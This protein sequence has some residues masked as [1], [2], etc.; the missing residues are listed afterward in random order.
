ML[1]TRGAA[2]FSRQRRPEPPKATP[3][4]EDED[5]PPARNSGDGEQ[6]FVFG[7][8]E[9]AESIPLRIDNARATGRLPISLTG[10]DVV[11]WGQASYVDGSGKTIHTKPGR[12]LLVAGK[13]KE[14]G[15]ISGGLALCGGVIDPDGD[16]ELKMQT[17]DLVC[18]VPGT[19]HDLN[20]DI[21]KNNAP[22]VVRAVDGDFVAT[23]RVAGSFQPGAGRTG[24]KSVPYNG[25]GLLAWLDQGNYIRL[26]RGA[27]YRNGRVVGLVIFESRERGARADVHNKGGLDP[28]R[29]IW[30]R[31]ERHGKIISGFL[32]PD[33]R[34]WDQL[35]PM[36]IE[37]P[38][39]LTV[40]LDAVN[41]CSDPMTVRFHDY[42][43]H[44]MQGVPR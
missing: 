36:E 28:R 5:N 14:G 19:L 13:P 10:K 41:S 11:L 6:P 35:E 23:V 34:D 38:A 8:L 42:S 40:G 37:W 33:G 22:R 31:L 30:L 17:G 9:G 18:D 25:G 43:L 26:E 1:Y 29:D 27:M 7:P 2:K 20:I 16:C 24:P 4:P 44:M 12:Y 32:S 3:G 21:L 15:P 39:R